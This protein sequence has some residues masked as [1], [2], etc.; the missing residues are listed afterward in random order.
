[1]VLIKTSTFSMSIPVLKFGGTSVGS[2]TRMEEVAR[3]IDD[4]QTK[5]V[6]LSAVS[7]TTNKLLDLGE[8]IRVQ[9]IESASIKLNALR[10]EYKVFVET[11]LA[12]SH[13]IEQGYSIC[14]S[15]F[16]EMERLLWVNS[17][18]AGHE[19]WILAQGEL[20]STK[21]FQLYLETQSMR[22][23][24]LPALNFM[25]IDEYDEPD[26]EWIGERLQQELAPYNNQHGVYF[27][28]QGYIC[29]NAQ[30]EVD[31][32]KRGGSDH[33]ATLIGAALK[34]SEIQIWTDID[35]I[36]NNDPRVV[37]NTRPIRQVSYREAAELAYFGAKILHPTCVIPAEERQVP[38]RLKNTFKP[39]EFGTLISEESSG[40]AVTAIAAKDGI[41]AIRIQSGRMLHAYGFLRRVF[42]VFERHR[43]PIDMITTSEVSVSLTI[44]QSMH[45]KQIVAEL[46]KFSEVNVDRDQSIICIVGDL[47][48]EHTEVTRHIFEA[49][50]NVPLRMVSY[51]GSQNNISLLVAR[52]QRD[53]AL[54]SL[55]QHLFTKPTTGDALLMA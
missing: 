32:L 55:H 37:Q 4:R 24:L 21:L 9:Q 46:E 5:I 47:L 1:M 48:A 36:H 45:L 30:G 15:I 42:E 33:S 50:E 53:T 44:D 40:L 25:R 29:R 26:L 7:G 22:S 11:L 17:F 16:D 34:S 6:V 31:N 38:I 54:R 27:I 19:K 35:G 41:T 18:A 13:L 52:D 23:V 2:P 20:I 10:E 51:G 14:K 43:T 39:A 28:T 49:L 8:T 3:L 12:D